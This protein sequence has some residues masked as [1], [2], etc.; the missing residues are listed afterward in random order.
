MRA[1]HFSDELNLYTDWLV[2]ENLSLSAG[3]GVMF[4]GDGA[5][6]AI[7]DDETFHL[8]ELGLYFTF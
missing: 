8:L 3:Y 7:G 4:P 6:Q 2:H 1:R 5:I